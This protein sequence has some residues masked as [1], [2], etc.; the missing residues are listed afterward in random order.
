MV[1]E[2]AQYLMEV[3][4]EF[5]ARAFMLGK[6]LGKEEINQEPKQWFLDID[7]PKLNIENLI[8]QNKE[9]EFK[10]AK[11]KHN[12]PPKYADGTFTENFNGRIGYYKYRFYH[13]TKDY[14]VYGKSKNECFEKRFKKTHSIIHDIAK[15]N[16]KN[17]VL[18]LTSWIHRYFENYRR[19]KCSHNEQLKYKKYINEIEMHFGNV[20]LKKISSE[21]IQIFINLFES[22]PRKMKRIAQFIKPAFDKAFA[23]QHVKHDPCRA[24]DTPQYTPKHFPVITFAEQRLI[25]ENILNPK[26]KELF[27]FCC[28]TGLR[29]GEAIN[30]IPNIDYENNIVYVLDEDTK[31]KKHRREIPILPNVFEKT[32][33]EAVSSKRAAQNYFSNL[34]KRLGLQAVTHSTRVT[35]ISICMFINI[36]H[37]QIQEWSG[38]THMAMTIDTYAKILRK[39][40]TTPILDYLFKL[41]EHL[42]L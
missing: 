38:H 4:Q 33:L 13:N 29:I 9:I 21:Q 5:N 36:N 39:D 18:T 23:L 31:T 1:A 16:K 12:M 11:E 6:L 20:P 3:A 24:V 14:Y 25:L 37:K 30:A 28:C 10:V 26:Y 34:F 17:A 19:N 42:E 27:M 15:D 22:T 32:L 7:I 41:K 2:T 8:S 35:F 40:G